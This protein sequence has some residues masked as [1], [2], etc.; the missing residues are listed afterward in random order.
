VY[1]LWQAQ[2]ELPTRLYVAWDDRGLVTEFPPELAYSLV[3]DFTEPRQAFFNPGIGAAFL[4]RYYM[5]TGIE[6][7]LPI[8]RGLLQL[9][10]DG[11]ELQYDYPDTIQIGKFAWGA[12][13]MLEVEPAEQHLR[14]VLRMGDWYADSELKDGSW[15]P[16]LWRTPEP[17]DVDALWKTAEHVLHITTMLTALAGYHRRASASS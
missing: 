2:P 13:A 10:E 9:S 12:A 17:T 7:A 11:T 5:Q 8:A 4:A 16:S 3:T 1:S 14:N 15:V 6:D